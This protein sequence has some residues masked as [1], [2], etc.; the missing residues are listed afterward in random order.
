MHATHAHIRMHDVHTPKHDAHAHKHTSNAHTRKHDAR[1]FHS[2]HC[3]TLF[4][5][6]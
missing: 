3:D 1:T 5:F 4:R 2:I 6:Q